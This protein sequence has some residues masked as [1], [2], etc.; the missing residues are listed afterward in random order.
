[1]NVMFVKIWNWFFPVAVLACLLLALVHPHV[2]LRRGALACFSVAHELLGKDLGSLG[3]LVKKFL[4]R[5]EEVTAD[6]GHVSY[7]S[8]EMGHWP[9]S[10]KVS[11]Y[12]QER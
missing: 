6:A 2:S 7:V 9:F 4:K 5:Q 10:L 3:P 8:V 1:M 11:F 12:P